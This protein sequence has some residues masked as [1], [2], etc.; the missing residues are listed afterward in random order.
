MFEQ[1]MGKEELLE[2]TNFSLVKRCSKHSVCDIKTWGCARSLDTRCD[3]AMLP[4]FAQNSDQLKPIRIVQARRRRASLDRS[5]SF[6]VPWGSSA[7]VACAK[8]S[9]RLELVWSL[10]HLWYGV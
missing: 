6:G 8:R 3:S 9:V 10:F 2:Q 1:L 4:E 5:G 7:S